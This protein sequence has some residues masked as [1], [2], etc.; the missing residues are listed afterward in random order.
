[1]SKTTVITAR[2][3][4]DT[5]ALVD[6]IASARGRSRAWFVTQVV[7]RAARQEAELMAFL[8]E[9]IDDIA[10]GRFVDHD[11]VMADLDAMIAKHKARC[12]G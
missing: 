1:M 8:Q 11:T 6:K 12:E 10:A 9:G 3:A 7:E 2:I 4:P 5:L